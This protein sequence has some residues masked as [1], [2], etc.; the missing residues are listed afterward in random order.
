[1]WNLFLILY[2][3]EFTE[4]IEPLLENAKNKITEFEVGI[5]MVTCHECSD[6]ERHPVMSRDADVTLSFGAQLTEDAATFLEN[7]NN[8][9]TEIG[10]DVEVVGC[11]ES[12]DKEKYQ[13]W[14]SDAISPV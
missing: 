9:F 3:C 4:G 1:M 8:K 10:A 13:L 11:Q 7:A 2:C 5:E 12:S 14:P 6:K